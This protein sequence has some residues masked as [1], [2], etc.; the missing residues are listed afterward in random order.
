MSDK[1]VRPV[2]MY[3]WPESRKFFKVQAAMEGEKIYDYAAE[4]TDAL[5]QLGDTLPKGVSVLQAVR[6]LAK[7][8]ADDLETRKPNDR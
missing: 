5:K 8:V 6:G 2:A 7:S 1:Q 3:V 4:I